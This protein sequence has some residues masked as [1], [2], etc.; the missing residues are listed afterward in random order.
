MFC[1]VKIFL[2]QIYSVEKTKY[3]TFRTE[4]RIFYA[5]LR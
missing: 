5:Y 4:D 2:S 1:N 3:K